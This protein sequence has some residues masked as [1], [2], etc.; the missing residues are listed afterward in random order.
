MQRSGHITYR[1]CKSCSIAATRGSRRALLFPLLKPAFDLSY[2]DCTKC[3]S[4]RVLECRDLEQ[5]VVVEYSDLQHSIV[6]Q[7]LVLKAQA[8]ALPT[9]H[10]DVH[11]HVCIKNVSATRN[12]S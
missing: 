9:G 12:I 8:R 3:H 1:S 7:Q 5:S 11:V 6:T 4:L 2:I 10:R